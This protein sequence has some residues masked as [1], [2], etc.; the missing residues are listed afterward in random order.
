[1]ALTSASFSAFGRI[2]SDTLAGVFP[3]T[4]TIAGTSYACAFV[5]GALG[6]EV[7]VH[8]K[9]ERVEGE[10]RISTEAIAQSALPA[11]LQI[12]VI[13]GTRYRV[14]QVGTRPHEGSYRLSIIQ[15]G[16]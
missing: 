7:E 1:M 10:C 12:V 4:I 6:T 13:G 15:P 8:G 5:R 3:D 2:L 14:L 11:P 9:L 16:K